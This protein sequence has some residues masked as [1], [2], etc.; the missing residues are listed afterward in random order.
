MPLMPSPGRL[1]ILRTP[2]S[3]R[4]STNKSAAVLAMKKLLDSKKEWR[5]KGSEGF[6]RLSPP[7]EPCRGRRNPTEAREGISQRRRGVQSISERVKAEAVCPCVGNRLLAPS[8][9][10]AGWRTSPHSHNSHTAVP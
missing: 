5:T 8:Q 3:M 1:K 7:H 2:Q 9:H 10:P 6:L 4:R